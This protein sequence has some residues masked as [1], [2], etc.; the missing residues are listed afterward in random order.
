MRT[1]TVPQDTERY[2]FIACDLIASVG[3]LDFAGRVLKSLRS[4]LRPDLISMFLHGGEKPMLLG[5][6]TLAGQFDEQRAIRHYM[7]C[8]FREDPASEI[9]SNDLPSGE[10]LALYMNKAEVPSISYRRQC[11]DNPHI[12]DR[13]T[14]VRKT[15]LREAVSI[16]LYRD[17]RSGPLDQGHLDLALSL[18]PMLCAAAMRHCELSMVRDGRDPQRILLHL[19]ERFPT[20]TMREAQCAAGAIAGQTAEEIAS[21]LGLKSSSVITH[22]KRAYERLNVTGL[23]DL[24]MLYLSQG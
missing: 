18:S 11:Y 16:N 23:R 9:I 5:H 8:Y 14:L 12:V 3:R 20:L 24:T 21:G 19:I 22:R 13:F 2:G 6:G 15:G 7:S 4:T 10:T 17:E 1:L